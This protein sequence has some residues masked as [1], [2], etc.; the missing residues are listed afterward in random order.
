MLERI[1]IRIVPRHRCLH[2]DRSI[3]ASPASYKSN[4]RKRMSRASNAC[5]PIGSH[6]LVARLIR[7][8]LLP[9]VKPGT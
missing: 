8:R 7:F 5:D 2:S 1:G 6:A 9:L 3:A 4:S